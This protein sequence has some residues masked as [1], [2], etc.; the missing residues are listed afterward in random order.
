MLLRQIEAEQFLSVGDRVRLEV[1]PG[2]TVITGPNGVGKT[3]L[4]AC[5][6][7]GR[8]VVG[9]AAGDPAA[10][11]LALYESAG[12]DGAGSFTVALDLDLD[13]AWERQRVRAF[14]CAAYA[15]TMRDDPGGPSADDD[16]IVVR[17]WLQGDSLAPLW[18]GRLLVRYESAQARPWFAAW[19]FSYAGGTWHVVLEGDGSGQLRRGPADHLAQPAGAGTVRDFLL[20]SKPRAD[21]RLDF[22]VALE[23]MSAPVAFTVQP[24]AGGQGRVPASLRE[25]APGLS[26]TEHANRGFPFEFVLSSLLQRG[27]TLTDNRRL[28]L[29][30]RFSYA[31]IW[32]RGELRD[33]ADVAAELYRLKIGDARARERFGQVQATFRALTG[34]ALEVRAA[35]SSGRWPGAGDDHRTCRG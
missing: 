35:E 10:E 11:R 8:A 3:N 32:D 31:E 14:V 26:V 22:R 25:L 19:E 21:S 20:K 12:H 18:S 9:R 17:Q 30:R 23:K 2:L 34:R 13:Q 29:R 24:L 28:P 16:D 27:L 33:G 5:L 4:G 6:D 15:C 7:L 1:G